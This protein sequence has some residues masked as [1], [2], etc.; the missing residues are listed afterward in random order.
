MNF[1]LRELVVALTM[2]GIV[3]LCAGFFTKAVHNVRIAA[4]RTQDL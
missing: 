3:L 4:A 2:I 1:R